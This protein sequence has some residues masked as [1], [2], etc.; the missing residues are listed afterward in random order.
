VATPRRRDLVQ[1]LQD[2]SA[3]L[4]AT[5]EIL[6]ALGRS[7]TSPGT[8]LDTIVDRALG[9]CRADAALL[10][11][12]DG[13]VFRLSRT[14]GDV[15]QEMVDLMERHPVRLSRDS[16][17]GRVALDHR[18]QQIDDVL[19]D[20]DYGRRD[21][22]A[23]ADYRTLLS[24]PML[25][26]DEVV[27]VLQVWRTEVAP[28]DDRA[29][30]LLTTFA[31]QA[32]VAVR[33]L[34]L[35]TTLEQRS[36]ELAEKVE[37]L[38][39]LSDVGQVV[40]S[41]LDL[42]EVLSTIVMNAVRLTDT[43]GG[44][45]MEYDE[46][47]DAFSVRSAY[48]SSPEL[49]ERL[50]SIV[51]ERR[52]TL[53][54][55]A[56]L[57]RR[58]LEVPDLAATR[59]DPHLQVLYDDGWRSVLAVPMTRQDQMVG[60]LVIRRRTTGSFSDDTRD[61]LQTFASQSALAIVNARLFGELATK[62]S[63]LEIASQHKSE[64]LASMSHELRT[65]LNAVIGFS[66][67]LLDELFGEVNER[68]REYLRDIWTSGRHLL[69][70]L[71]EVLDLSKVEAGHME[72]EY[73]R[74]PV[75][76]ALGYALSLMR[77]RAANHQVGLHLEVADDVDLVEADELRFKQVLVNLLTNA[78]KFTPDGGNV[79]VAARLDG[80]DL[81]V[82]VADDGIG[83]PAQDRE[84]IFES[85]Q[86]GGRGAPK[87]EGTGLGLTLCRRIV[88]LLGGRM[89]LDSEVGVGST[90]GFSVPASRSAWHRD[91]TTEVPAGSAATV[92]VV[93]DDRTSQDLLAI[94][95]EGADVEVVRAHDGV[96][97]L[98]TVRRV[99]PAAVILDIRLPGM[100]GWQVL[101]DLKRDPQCQDVPVIVVSV[102]DE[103][104]K[105]MAL[106]AADYLVKPVQ[107]EQLLTVLANAR[108]LDVP[109]D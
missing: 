1:D 69:E 77:E 54:G 14:T 37:Q 29:T 48:G 102:V 23:V 56:T 28:F 82:T 55:R 88:E 41:S 62:T 3:Q 36:A 75:A 70:L 85:F 46:V 16:L 8:V 91:P 24:A 63:E 94:Y 47:A 22:Q 32:A 59:R 79:W 33:N 49:L 11:L 12:A 100:D 87:E 25:V 78:V 108:G 109:V 38:E 101:S 66:E 89:W 99:H 42:D 9:L 65:P 83:I 50:R 45:I 18:V 95:L 43:D 71:N 6:I 103:R 27:G 67:V 92:V 73:T 19:A 20:P 26:D 5:N 93:E 40:S 15:P 2:S 86:Q 106:G 98:A 35:L 51:I 39:A 52:S 104:A 97:G 4:A 10:S 74:F 60:A 21:L 64:F 90:F 81:V 68:Q 72:M 44:S 31:A 30:Q 34:A 13:E 57:D 76:D 84:R 53:V 7:S 80:P 107:R 58:P 96:E 61:I 17:V 105:G